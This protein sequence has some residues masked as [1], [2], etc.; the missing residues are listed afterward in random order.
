MNHLNIQWY[1]CKNVWCCI[2]HRF[3]TSVIMSKL[4]KTNANI[5]LLQ[6][7]TLSICF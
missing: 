5:I 6:K 7:I 2:V 4:D 3:T 1:S